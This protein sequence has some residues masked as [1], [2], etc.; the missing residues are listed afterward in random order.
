MKA[1]LMIPETFIWLLLSALT[2]A[3]WYVGSGVGDAE[4]WAAGAMLTIAFFKVRLVIMHF[5]ELRQ[6]PLPLKLLAELW[7]IVAFSGMMFFFYL[8]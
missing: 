6:A 7:V 8:Y 1:L 3:S 5:M 4:V 2:L